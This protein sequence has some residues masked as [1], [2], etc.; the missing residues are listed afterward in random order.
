M[1]GSVYKRCTRCGARVPDRRCEKCRAESPKWAFT[2]DIGKDN[3]GRR[4]QRARTGF[5]T[6]KAA[7]RALRELLTSL[8]ERRYVEPSRLTL[9]TYL[10]EHWLPARKPKQR[11]A[12]RRHRGQVSLGTWASYRSDL[13]A[14]VIPRIG[15][16]QL[17]DLAPATLN[18]LYDHLEEAGG[19]HGRGLAGKTVVN[20]HGI[21]H[22]ALKDAVKQGY[23]ERNVADAVDAPRARR[24]RTAV[25]TVEQLR[26]FLRHVQA[27]RLYAGW[28]LF[29]TTGMRR[30]EV[31]GLA[32]PD[33]DLD[34]GKVRIDWTL[35]VV[36]SKATWKRRTKSEAGERVMSLDPATVEAFR[37]HRAMQAQERLRLG[38]HWRNRQ[39][40]WQGDYREDLAFTW[41]DGRLIDPQRW[42][43]W[44]GEHCRSAGLPV[45]RLHD[46]RHTYATAAL[47]N[48]RGWHDIKVIS[49]RLGHAS[50]GITLDTYA[51]VLP[52]ADEE[53]AHSLATLILGT[54]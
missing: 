6:R 18:R 46:V 39:H 8:D 30:G 45:I 12:G 19:R 47:A 3:H 26:A 25:W 48:A 49:E 38:P 53:T 52:K 44:F 28:L 21:L 20:V 51:H 11:D 10:I 22:K 9:E 14:H 16:V 42:S 1:S 41:P 43:T 5:A 29:A 7:D 32:W 17:Q 24:P 35:G 34:H 37:A 15:G 54:A 31:A 33:L 13:K 50:T 36:D 2:V 27:E 40:D 23:L 4:K